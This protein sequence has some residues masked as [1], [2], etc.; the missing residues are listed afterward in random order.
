MDNNTEQRQFKF[1]EHKLTLVNTAMGIVTFLF[2]VYTY[3]LT[4]QLE[5]YKTK[6]KNSEEDIAKCSANIKEINSKFE[7]IENDADTKNI[8]IMLKKH[9]EKLNLLKDAVNGRM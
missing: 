2:A 1:S 6:I 4:V 7:K 8:G 3:F 5:N 9:D